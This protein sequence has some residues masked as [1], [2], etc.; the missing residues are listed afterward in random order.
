MEPAVDSGPTGTW[1]YDCRRGGRGQGSVQAQQA[2]HQLE[3]TQLT[4]SLLRSVSGIDGTIL[5]D[6]AGF[7]H[8]FGIILDGEATDHCTPSQ[9]SRYNSAVRYVQAGNPRRLA[10]IVSDD[11]T[12][13]IIPRIIGLASRSK[14]E[15]HIAAFEAATFD[16]Y[17]DSRIG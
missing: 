5:L 17:H 13:N 7:C 3:P 6:P 11:R 12:I 14:I 1:Q 2:G 9:G 4:E 10:I 15:R 8:A 16:N